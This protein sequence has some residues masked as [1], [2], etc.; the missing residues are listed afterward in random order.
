MWGFL[1]MFVPRKSLH[2]VMES[3]KETPRQELDSSLTTSL[4]LHDDV[5]IENFQRF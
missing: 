5:F 3:V 1:R 4:R 2:K